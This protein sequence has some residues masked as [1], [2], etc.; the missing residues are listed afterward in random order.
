M[1]VE[2]IPVCEPFYR[3]YGVMSVDESIISSFESKILN[4]FYKL[5]SSASSPI[6]VLDTIIK[7]LFS[8]IDAE[9]GRLLFFDEITGEETVIISLGDN[10]R[11]G[12]PA[13]RGRALIKRIQRHTTGFP[14]SETEDGNN[15]TAFAP[16]MLSGKVIGV[17]EANR[18]NG[19]T[20]FSDTELTMI[21]RIAALAV[22]PVENIRL[23][24]T[25]DRSIKEISELM[26]ISAILNSSLD[27][28][29]VRER[30]ITVITR[31]LQCDVASLLLVDE[32]T[33]ELY[34]EVALGE[35][36]KRVKEI[37][38][39]KGE[40]IAGWV[41]TNNQPVL[42]DDVKSD[43]RHSGRFDD[44]SKFQ[45]RSM[46]CVPMVIKNKV[47]GVL[48]AIN[49]LGDARFSQTD[50]DLLISLS[51]E[52]AIAVDNARLYNE[53]RETFYQ[54]AQALADAIEKRDPYTGNH[55]RRV[56]HYSMAIS[57]FMDLSEIEI[58]NL[59][60]AAILH[61]IGKIG[62]EDSVLRKDGELNDEEYEKIIRHPEIGVDILGHIK[63]LEGVIPGMKSHHERIDGTGYPEK[64][65]DGDIP[66]I[67]R[68]IAVADT[69]DAMTTDRP[70]RSALTD[71]QAMEELKRFVGTQFD[72][73]VVNAFIK[74]YEKGYIAKSVDYRK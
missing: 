38:L 37:R 26:E 59:R 63:R 65:K 9:S 7:T 69:F 56:M 71:K 74:S 67:A 51:H 21:E 8:Q 30:A 42:I 20:S 54:T 15:R 10:Q 57:R 47:V 34:F 17:I 43:P 11:V 70:Y 45:T 49:K 35:K 27:T 46:I 52:V 6:D 14:V 60:L 32:L 19:R 41:V 36:G 62:V 2:F 64:I 1:Y 55:T 31:L 48:Q 72:R 40:G 22:L 13:L 28:G 29:S 4:E 61:D 5:S 23:E 33:D 53:L 58:E 24:K 3:L 44:R 50:L 18:P 68:I 66:L 16:L 25:R 39:K 73:A 12:N